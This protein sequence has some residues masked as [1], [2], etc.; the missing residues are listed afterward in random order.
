MRILLLI[1][2]VYGNESTVLHCITNT[3]LNK[4]LFSMSVKIFQLKELHRISK[5]SLIDA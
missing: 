4:L 1:F 3:E 5:L 2:N